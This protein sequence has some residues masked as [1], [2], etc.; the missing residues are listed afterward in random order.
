MSRPVPISGPSRHP[1]AAV[2][3]AN[4]AHGWLMCDSV[5]RMEDRTRTADGGFTAASAAAAC[6]GRSGALVATETETLAGL[7]TRGR[8][9]EREQEQRRNA[10]ARRK[11]EA[12]RELEVLRRQLSEPWDEIG[13][14]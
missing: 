3:N 14:A 4:P 2:P 11:L 9:T 5:A 8:R 12:R 13:S 10:A 6:S 1:N 7:T